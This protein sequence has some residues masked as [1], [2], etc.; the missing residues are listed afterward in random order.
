M[1]E[2]GL[3]VL[4]VAAASVNESAAGVVLLIPRVAL[5]R[6]AALGRRDTPSALEDS[7]TSPGRTGGGG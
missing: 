1:R 4:Q 3:H 5:A 7:G 6:L 2:R